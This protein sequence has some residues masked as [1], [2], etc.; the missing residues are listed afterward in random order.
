MHF[1]IELKNW[2][3]SKNGL[4]NPLYSATKYI[5]SIYNF[6]YNNNVLMG[7]SPCHQVE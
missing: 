6:R 7:E 4:K 2:L 1:K 3:E 5:R